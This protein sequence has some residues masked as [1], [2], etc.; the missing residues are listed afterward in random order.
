MEAP[1][2]WFRGPATSRSAW[3]VA[4]ALA[5]A[6][7]ASGCSW[8]GVKRP[9]PPGQPPVRCTE[10]PAAPIVDTVMAALGGLSVLGSIPVFAASSMSK[11]EGA[12]LLAIIV[13]VPMVAAGAFT[14]ALYGS[15]A[16]YGYSA[17]R[18]CRAL[19]SP[20]RGGTTIDDIGNNTIGG[21]SL[22]SDLDYLLTPNVAIGAILNIALGPNISTI[23]PAS[24]FVGFGLGPQLKILN[25]SSDHVPYVRVAL[26]FRVLAGLSSG[27]VIGLGLLQVGAG[28][29]YWFHRRVGFGFDASLLPTLVLNGYYRSYLWGVSFSSGLELKF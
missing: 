3:V 29:R 11:G 8:I 7:S 1:L 14:A 23:V 20:V 17:T 15:S 13:G 22:F 28:Y 2:V 24:G 21:F 16:A 9:A 27:Y 4:G 19:Y 12:G 26:P 25:D 5:L 6:N 18:E 10:S